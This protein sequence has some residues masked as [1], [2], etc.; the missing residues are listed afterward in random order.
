MM[1]NKQQTIL[2]FLRNL[3]ANNNRDWFNAHKSE[4]N[5]AQEAFI[6]MM[7]ALIQRIS[8]FDPETVGIEPKSTVFRIYRDTRFSLDKRPYKQHFGGFVNP[9][10][11]KS[12]SSGYYFHV[13]PENIM[14]AGGSYGVP[15]EV[16]TSIRWSIVGQT[17]RFR[18][19][20][21]EKEFKT[22]YPIIGMERL[23]TMP[24]GFPKDFAY[25]DYLRPKDYDI[26]CLLTEK[27]FLSKDW[28]DIS[29]HRF[30]VMKPFLDFVN[31]TVLDYV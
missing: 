7:D 22:L 24:K 26:W 19:I 29:A 9:L 12:F 25:P 14:L 28:L 15:K 17:E 6:D 4:F 2:S 23:K 21:E 27:E 20:V 8:L 11:R 3:A 13:E 10:G 16:L 18:D 30:E 5:E 31:E 1:P